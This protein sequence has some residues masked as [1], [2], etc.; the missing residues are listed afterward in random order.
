MQGSGGRR[1][2]KGVKVKSRRLLL[3]QRR[4]EMMVMCLILCPLG[5]YHR[6][7]LSIPK[8]YNPKI[9]HNY[10]PWVD[11]TNVRELDNYK[12]R[13]SS[14]EDD[15][16]GEDGS[17]DEIHAEEDDI[18]EPIAPI[19]DK[20]V[21]DSSCADAADLLEHV[22]VSS[23]TALMGKIIE[24]SNV[25]VNVGDVSRGVDDSEGITVNV[26]NVN[27]TI[28][29]AGKQASVENFG[30]AVDPSVKETVDGLKEN[31]PIK[32][33][34]GRPTIINTGN[35][36]TKDEDVTP[37]VRD[38]TME[39][40]AGL[41]DG[42]ETVTPSVADTGTNDDLSEGG[43]EPTIGKGDA[44]TLNTEKMEIP[45]DDGQKKKRSKKRKHEKGTD[46]GE[47]FE[48]KKRLSKEECAYKRV[49]RAERKAKKAT[50]KTAKE[51][52]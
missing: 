49:R 19:V 7:T 39:D 32:G 42:R 27:N 12:P 14:N 40:D 2:Q 5:F 41:T 33:D 4:K 20:K 51:D 25:Y 16:V 10:L 8:R 29:D 43:A 36:T 37:S 50:E 28:T 52:V 6:W 34:E 21:R 23:D 9:H 18:G 47:A 30:K 17:R 45:E 15:D 3:R 46:E 38:T 1:N 35:D 11:Y 13:N 22:V 24:P 26:S 44:Y 48:P 31:A